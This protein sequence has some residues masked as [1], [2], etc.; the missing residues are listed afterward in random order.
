MMKLDERIIVEEAKR[1][2]PTEDDTI[3]FSDSENFVLS[4]LFKKGPD[5]DNDLEHYFHDRN[6][7]TP[8]HIEFALAHD[9]SFE[10]YVLADNIYLIVDGGKLDTSLS[11]QS[12][13][14]KEEFYKM[15]KNKK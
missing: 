7:L 9:F 3:Q 12:Q 10:F 2:C 5:I 1:L 15:I 14:F 4:D 8:E 13:E 6:G 11:C